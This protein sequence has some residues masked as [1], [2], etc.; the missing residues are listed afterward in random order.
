DRAAHR[1]AFVA[2]CLTYLQEAIGVVVV[3][4]V[5]S[6][7]W[8][9]HDE[10]MLRLSGPDATRWDADLYAVAYRP[11]SREGELCLDIWRE[12]LAVGRALPTM[13]LWLRGAICL[14]IELAAT[15]E[16]TCLEQR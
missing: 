12:A 2:K 9:L 15:Y 7:S 16:R 4:I 11:V 8:N 6:R 14:P 13:P 10:L 1:D 3:D 5:T